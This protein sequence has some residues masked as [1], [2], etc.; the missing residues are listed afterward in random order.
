MV[1]RLAPRREPK[2]EI[3]CTRCAHMLAAAEPTARRIGLQ[4]QTS[5]TCDAPASSPTGLTGWGFPRR[6][7]VIYAAHCDKLGGQV[8][9]KV[10]SKDRTSASKLR[11][12]KREAAMM[13]YL[14][15]KRCAFATGAT[16]VLIPPRP[17]CNACHC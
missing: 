9:V 2:R 17:A 8:A 10:Y 1:T 7:S 16:R 4:A 3:R 15:K 14:S 11:A 12:I 13:V 6:D 5:G